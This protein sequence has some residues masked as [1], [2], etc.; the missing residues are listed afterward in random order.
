MGRTPAARRGGRA[1]I[2][3]LAAACVVLALQLVELPALSARRFRVTTV[4]TAPANDARA[5]A[6]GRGASTPSTPGAPTAPRENFT[7]SFDAVLAQ[8]PAPPHTLVLTFGTVAVLDFALNWVEHVSRVRELEPFVVAALDTRVLD[9][10]A[11]RG[12]VR[13]FLAPRW[14]IIADRAYTPERQHRDASEYFRGDL[15]AFKKMGHVKSLT[16][17]ALLERGYSVLVSD[18]DVIWLRHPWGVLHAPGKLAHARAADGAADGAETRTTREA[19]A[20]ADVLL[21]TDTV[22]FALDSSAHRLLEA[23]INTGV[24]FVRSSASAL[25]F[26]LEWA[27]RCLHT[28][29]GHDQQE[30]NLLLKGCYPPEG[31]RAGVDGPRDPADRDLARCSSAPYAPTLVLAAGSSTPTGARVTTVGGREFVAYVPSVPSA[32]RLGADVAEPPGAKPARPLSRARLVASLGELAR[33]RRR[34]VQWMWHGRLR[35]AVLPMGLFLGGHTFFVQHVHARAGAPAPVAVHLSWGFGDLFGKRE[36]LRE[37]GWWLVEDE[38]YFA[39]E[40]RYVRIAHIDAVYERAVE[41][42]RASAQRCVPAEIASGRPES[43][44]WHPANLVQSDVAIGARDPRAAVDPAAPQLA[45]QAALRRALRNGFALAEATGRVL[46]LPE[47]RCYCE[48]FWWL[49]EDCRVAGAASMELP[50]VCPFD[51][52]FE[53]F[54]WDELRVQRRYASFW[55]DRRLPPHVLASVAAVELFAAHSGNGA[56]APRA[57]AIVALAAPSSVGGVSR[58]VRASASASAAA[59]LEIDGIQLADLD[60]CV[61]GMKDGTLHAFNDRMSKLLGGLSVEYCS[62]ERNPFLAEE[63]PFYTSRRRDA[64]EALN[65]SYPG[66]DPVVANPITW[67]RRISESNRRRWYGGDLRACAS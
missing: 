31:A 41:P 44:C 18:V 21:G 24:L 9:A 5:V 15:S 42:F 7:G 25:A 40:A 13:A 35:A 4:G 38:R 43:A 57:A 33:A 37:Q 17:A 8:L 1:A 19:L 29:D 45:A 64:K 62:R 20:E 39:Q 32:P 23:E 56:R 51:F 49:L 36:R 66:A 27:H 16:L 58:A 63:A 22:D 26:V 47:L 54:W 34:A 11:A 30:F 53:P 52:L 60:G 48:R 67:A 65:C 59:I 50:F 61:E 14:Q 55:N 10:L 12:G 2:A 28:R 6:A 3:M 46:V